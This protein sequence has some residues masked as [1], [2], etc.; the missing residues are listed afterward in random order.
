MNTKKTAATLAMASLGIAAAQAAI[1]SVNLTDGGGGFGNADI[2]E[3]AGVIEAG[4]WETASAS[5]AK[6]DTNLSAL[7][8]D[9]DG[10]LVTTTATMTI[11]SGFGGYY[12]GASGFNT[13]TA[14]YS[15]NMMT[16][17]M[18]TGT[19]TGGTIGF[20]NL[21]ASVGTTY[22]VYVYMRRPFGNTGAISVTVDGTTKWI[23]PQHSAGPFLEAD[24][25]TQAEAQVDPNNG[26][27]YILFS[28]V[29]SD[30][31]DIV[32]GDNA[33]GRVGINGIQIVEAVP[34]P[35]AAALLGLGGVALILRRRK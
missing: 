10:S 29:T 23:E 26:G 22:D 3:K 28:G 31:I 5:G 30:S 33:G 7:R 13:A 24:Y 4:G 34:E 35:S 16:N 12:N 11:S 20:T 19:N 1:I 14:L 21:N 17:F 25:A 8:A 32:L 15:N 2:T 6:N 9:D 18:E 27:H